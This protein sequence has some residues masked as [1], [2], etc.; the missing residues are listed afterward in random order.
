LKKK[1][2]ET[3]LLKKNISEFYYVDEILNPSPLHELMINKYKI[4]PPI[5]VVKSIQYGS[6]DIKI[7]KAN[8]YQFRVENGNFLRMDKLFFFNPSFPLPKTNFKFAVDNLMGQKNSLYDSK[9]DTHYQLYSS[10][11]QLLQIK[12]R[13]LLT[14]YLFGYKQQYPIAKILNKSYQDAITQSNINISV[15]DNPDS[16]ASLLQELNKLYTLSNAIISSYTYKPL[17][18][19]TSERLPNGRTTFYEYDS[20]NRLILIK[21]QFGSILKQYAYK[22]AK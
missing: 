14:S 4:D 10:I 20:F 19:I 9:E 6:G 17:V 18:G 12:Q 8:Y 5:E 22:Y 21:D 15:I 3:S 2:E 1:T 7:A 11:G 13:G 16:D